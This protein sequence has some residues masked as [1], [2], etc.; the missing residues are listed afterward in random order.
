MRQ[1]Q[2]LYNSMAVAF[3]KILNGMKERDFEKLRN[4][5]PD[6]E[7]SI[8]EGIKEVLPDLF[9]LDTLNV[10]ELSEE[11]LRKGHLA[12]KVGVYVCFQE[13]LTTLVYLV[14]HLD[15]FLEDMR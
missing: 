7:K 10:A 11:Q 9:D 13:D 4:I 6:Y 12:E 5:K 8:I 3:R 14:R 15:M 2:K 1:I